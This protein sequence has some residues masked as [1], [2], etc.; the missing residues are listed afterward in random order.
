MKINL[1]SRWVVAWNSSR[2]FSFAAFDGKI[3]TGCLTKTR[4]TYR[5]WNEP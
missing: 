5:E 1:S 3:W 2:D 4:V